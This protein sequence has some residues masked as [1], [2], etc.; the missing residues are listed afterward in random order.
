LLS[1]EFDILVKPHPVRDCLYEEAKVCSTHRLDY[2]DIIA[3]QV[4]KITAEDYPEN[5]GLHEGNILLRKHTDLVKE[6]G[7]GVWDMI[8]HG[9]HRDQ[10]AMDYVAWKLGLK[11]GG[12]S[13]EYF[14]R[15]GHRKN[16]RS[17][18]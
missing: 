14:E 3:Q 4:A 15:E 8:E 1:D 6:F 10:L 18:P 7:E 11:I 16:K 5:Y 12:L 9:S 17:Y 2:K 13:P